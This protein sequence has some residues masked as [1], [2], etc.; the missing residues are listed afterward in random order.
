MPKDGGSH[1]T[2]FCAGDDLFV[3]DLVVIAV[4]KKIVFIVFLMIK[5]VYA[6]Y[7]TLRNNPQ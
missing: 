1:R 2:G 5:V 7:R 4:F 6:H 3:S